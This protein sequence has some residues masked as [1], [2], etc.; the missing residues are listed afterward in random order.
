MRLIPVK[1]CRACK[2]PNLKDAAF[3]H[4]CGTP[5][6]GTFWPY[7]VI[8]AAG[9]LLVLLI[10]RPWKQEVQQRP[11]NPHLSGKIPLPGARTMAASNPTGPLAEVEALMK[12]THTDGSHLREAIK[13]LD[14]E[15]ETYPGFAY[16]LR[17]R[18]SLYGILNDWPNAVE[19]YR[20][21]LEV[22]PEDAHA[23]LSLASAYLKTEKPG[24][25][26]AECER[27]YQN[28]PKFS[29][30]LRVMQQ[31][32]EAMGENAQAQKFQVELLQAANLDPSKHQP[33][34]VFHPKDPK[35]SSQ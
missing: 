7:P 5:V 15:V 29:K 3:C 31:A 16:G 28:Y 14:H 11:E 18:A 10:W 22:A 19:A 26:L 35:Q 2:Q 32:Y 8:I 9:L 4:H 6:S 23:R 12:K 17:L 21:Y 27:I 25:A 1:K 30:L 20:K 34:R 33:P 13:I 24:E